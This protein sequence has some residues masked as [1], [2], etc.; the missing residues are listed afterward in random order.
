MFLVDVSVLLRKHL[1]IQIKQNLEPE[2]GKRERRL[3]ASR[4]WPRF[5]PATM[6]LS[7]VSLRC[8]ATRTLMWDVSPKELED[9]YAG[10][11]DGGKTRVRKKDLFGAIT[12]ATRS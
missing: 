3:Q 8:N 7:L 6:R 12:S 11:T 2:T 1:P 4:S 9:L 5:S 10:V